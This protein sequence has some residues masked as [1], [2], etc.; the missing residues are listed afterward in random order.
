ML[1]PAAARALSEIVTTHLLELMTARADLDPSVTAELRHRL[2]TRTSDPP[3][4]GNCEAKLTSERAYAEAQAAAADGTLSED[5]VLRAA[6]RGEARL[7]SAMLAVATGVPLSVV[8][9]AVSLRSAKGLVSLCWK[10]GFSMRVAGPLQSLLAR[11]PPPS[12]LPPGPNGIF[13][14]ATEEM[15]WQLEFL[16][17]MGC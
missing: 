3:A 8:E 17:R 4:D 5:A 11:I 13:P 15:R 14:L 7:A 6:Q 12:I 9:R 1:P 10:A 16:D 2:G